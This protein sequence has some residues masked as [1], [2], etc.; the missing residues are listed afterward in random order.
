M[1]SL[2]ASHTAPAGATEGGLR[3]EHISDSANEPVAGDSNIDPLLGKSNETVDLFARLQ[4]NFPPA[5]TVATKKAPAKPVA[6]N[7]HYLI[8]SQESNKATKSSKPAT[9][10]KLAKAPTGKEGSGRAQK[11]TESIPNA[12]TSPEQSSS[13]STS[14]PSGPSHSLRSREKCPPSPSRPAEPEAKRVK[15]NGGWYAYVEVDDN[16]KEIAEVDPQAVTDSDLPKSFVGT[17]REV[18]DHP[19]IDQVRGLFKSPRTLRRKRKFW[20]WPVRTSDL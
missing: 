7:R 8:D 18:R 5:K 6:Q 9:A 12:S 20:E 1:T 17:W 14:A 3:E 15:V 16:G 11:L 13:E 19:G 10:S 2:P 4:T